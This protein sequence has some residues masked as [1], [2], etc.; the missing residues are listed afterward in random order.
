M[1]GGPPF[2]GTFE[3][4]ILIDQVDLEKAQKEDSALLK[5]KSWFNLNT[6]KVDEKKES[7]QRST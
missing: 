2:I 6:G 5:V 3:G 1:K 7:F 4:K